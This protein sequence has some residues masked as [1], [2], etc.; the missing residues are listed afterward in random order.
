MGSLPELQRAARGRPV[1]IVAKFTVLGVPAPQGSKN[2]FK[3]KGGKTVVSE[4]SPALPAW[5]QAVSAEALRVREE[6]GVTLDGALRLDAEFRFAMPK[7]APAWAKEQGLMLHTTKPDMDK[8]VRALGDSCKDAGLIAEDSR[9]A[10]SRVAKIAVWNAW[11][12]VVVRIR[13]VD[14]RLA[15]AELRDL[16]S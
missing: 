3:T 7:S 12:G 8:L 10:V 16:M 14:Q 6:L 13:Q 9:I 5:R 1:V 2:A 4:G 15:R 11:T